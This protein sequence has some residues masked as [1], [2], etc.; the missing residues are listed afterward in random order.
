MGVFRK[1]EKDI[2]TQTNEKGLKSVQ[3][4]A[5]LGPDLKDRARSGM[6]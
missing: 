5:L 1:Q 3:V 6:V 4:L 2:A